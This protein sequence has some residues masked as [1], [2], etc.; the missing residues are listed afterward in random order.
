[1]RN[2]TQFKE[3]LIL[4]TH[5][6]IYINKRLLLAIKMI[7][8][9]NYITSLNH[10]E[11]EELTSSFQFRKRNIMCVQ[12]SIHELLITIIKYVRNNKILCYCC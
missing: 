11:I 3:I 10:Q 9:T 1:M 2:F 5:I 4:D 8:P 6:C 7:D 12:T